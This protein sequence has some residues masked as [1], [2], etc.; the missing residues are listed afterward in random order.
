VA[1]MIDS[2][3]ALEVPALPDGVEWKAYVD[4]WKT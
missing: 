3:D 2:R 1:V 4:S